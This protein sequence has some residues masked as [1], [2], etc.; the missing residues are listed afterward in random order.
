MLI[1]SCFLVIVCSFTTEASRLVYLFLSTHLPI[2]GSYGTL[3]LA[4]SWSDPLSLHIGKT[5]SRKLR[6]P[7]G[8]SLKH[9]L[10]PHVSVLSFCKAFCY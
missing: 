6:V 3:D 1:L 9:V 4:E 8:P 5:R 7:K 10:L 2:E